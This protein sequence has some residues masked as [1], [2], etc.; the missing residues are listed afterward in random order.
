M[1]AQHRALTAAGLA[2]RS[3]VTCCSCVL[4]ASGL[5][6]STAF[7]IV[8][9][10]KQLASRGRTI[11]LTIHSPSTKIFALFDRLLLLTP[12]EGGARIAFQGPASEVLSYFD[13]RLDLGVER[14][15]ASLGRSQSA[16][17][18]ADWLMAMLQNRGRNQAKTKEGHKRTPSEIKAEAKMLEAARADEQRIDRIVCAYAANPDAMPDE[19]VEH[20]AT[21][22]RREEAAIAQGK[23]ARP[24]SASLMPGSAVSLPWLTQLKHLTHRSF[25][26]H[27]RSLPQL[28]ARL[29]TNVFLG[30]FVGLL[31]LHT[32]RSS[33]PALNTGFNQT[34]IFNRV[35]FIFFVVGMQALITLV[36]SV[37]TCRTHTRAHARKLKHPFLSRRCPSLCS[38]LHVCCLCSHRGAL[39]VCSRV[40]LQAV[41]HLRLLPQQDDRRD[42]AGDCIQRRVRSHR[43]RDGRYERGQVTTRVTHTE[44]VGAAATMHSLC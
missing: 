25:L 34:S 24:L 28:R 40:Q 23:D 9:L 4:S 39:S 16:M 2:C 27:L 12:F 8:A 13:S 41:L 35:G 20:L 42:S 6:S 21:E 29:F 32:D 36:T 15:C 5:D 10:L 19:L 3:W 38:A 26:T 22:R 30:L 43:L 1:T 14:V 44:T 18:V 31:Y 37:L 11:V 33:P 17:T 7:T